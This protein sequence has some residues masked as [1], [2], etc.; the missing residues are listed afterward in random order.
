MV[1]AVSDRV[2]NYRIHPA[3]KYLVTPQLDRL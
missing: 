1:T 2:K 3:E